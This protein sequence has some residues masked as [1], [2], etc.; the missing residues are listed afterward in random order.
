L[1]DGWQWG[2][3]YADD[4]ILSD[5]VRQKALSREDSSLLLMGQSRIVKVQGA[6]VLSWQ[7]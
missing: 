4:S 6:T 3:K 5:K 7:S 1:S 2:E